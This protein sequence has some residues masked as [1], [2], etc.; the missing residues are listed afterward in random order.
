MATTPAGRAEPKDFF[1]WLGAIVAFYASITSFLT[2][3]FQYINYTYPDSLAGYGD[4]YGGLVRTSMAT[5][6]VLAPTAVILFNLIRRSIR[7]DRS[8]KDIWVRRWAIVLTLFIAAAVAL[9]DLI[10]LINT[11]LGGEITTRFTLK[12]VVI[13]LVAGGVLLHFIADMKGYWFRHPRRAQMV[14]VGFGALALASVVAGFFI[15]GT[16]SDMRE[17][18]FDEQRVWDLQSIQWQVVNYWQTHEELPDTLTDLNDPISSFM[19]PTD[20]KTG[21]PYEYSTAGIN[22]FSLCATFSQPTPD[23]EG[24][25]EFGMSRP[26]YDIAP[27]SPMNESFEHGAGRECFERIIDPKRYPPFEQKELRTM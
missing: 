26:M 25:G 27:S 1:L 13:L 3:L 8:K 24:R 18:R 23:M 11:F 6:I 4:P 16:P 12:A 2:L 15:I 14:G 7:A 21:E 17:R 19:V 20:P 10:T 9:V 22:S 5:L